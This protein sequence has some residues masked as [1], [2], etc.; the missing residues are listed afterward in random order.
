MWTWDWE[1][2][3]TPPL[4]KR[5]KIKGGFVAVERRSAKIALCIYKMVKIALCGYKQKCSFTPTFQSEQ[6]SCSEK[7]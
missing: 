4:E 6:G 3:F 2:S 1:I 5:G 7:M